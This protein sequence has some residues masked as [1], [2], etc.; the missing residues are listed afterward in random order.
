MNQKIV[1]FDGVCN[2]CSFWVKFASK[3]DQHKHLKFASLQSEI[4]KQLL[5]QNN[6]STEEL[7]SVIFIDH[8]KAY[9]K[10]SAALRICRNLDGGWKLLYIMIFIPPFIRD[11]IYDFVARNRYRW[12]GKSES[13]MMPT[14]EMKD[15]F[16]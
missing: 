5:K 9:T 16:L 10:S 13:C 8:N 14:E 3:R 15:R 2:F 12:F 4:G 11:S 6:I 7:N 1:L